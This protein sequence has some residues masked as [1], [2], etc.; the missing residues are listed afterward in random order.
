MRGDTAVVISTGEPETMAWSSVDV[1]W[2]SDELGNPFSMVRAA[3]RLVV[4]DGDRVHVVSFDGGDVLSFGRA[5]D[6]PGEFGRIVALGVLARDSIAVYDVRLHRLSV[7]S[8]AGEFRGSRRVAPSIPFVNPVGGGD[9]FIRVGSGV[10]WTRSENALLGEPTRV[11]LQWYDLEVD[12]AAVLEVWDDRQFELLSG[13]LIGPKEVFPARAIVAV[14]SDGRFA[15]GNGLEYCVHVRTAFEEDTVESW[16][17]ERDRI[18]VGN[19]VRLP[20]LGAPPDDAQAAALVQVWRDQEAGEYLPHFDLIRFSETG[21]L[22]V[23]TLHDELANVHP[24]VLARRPELAPAWRE[25]EVFGSDGAL[26]R[27]AVLPYTFD[28]RVIGPDGMHGF[29]TL[30]S[31]E[32]VLAAIEFDAAEP[33]QSRAGNGDVS[34]ITQA[35][36]VKRVREVVRAGADQ[37]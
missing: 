21:D 13:G 4:G 2:R 14:G 25:W 6:G 33:I 7:F 18:P 17:R 9:P 35:I 16:C 30:E 32:V 26:V 28:P 27:K 31:G 11:A 3:D 29:F 10:L 8:M 37:P 36:D 1:I 20:D 23:R 24:S 22:W 5:G 34:E 12:S 15:Q 19:G